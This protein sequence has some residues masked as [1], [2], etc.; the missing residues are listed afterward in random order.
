ML[1]SLSN[2]ECLDKAVRGI[3]VALVEH[4]HSNA[5]SENHLARIRSHSP[6]EKSNE[7]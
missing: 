5:T 2:Y 7:A 3:E 6:G 4:A 1:F